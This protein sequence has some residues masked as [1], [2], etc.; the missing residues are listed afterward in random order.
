MSY[1]MSRERRLSQIHGHDGVGAPSVE[2]G[3]PA[4]VRTEGPKSA[5]EEK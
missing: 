3:R 4:S 2:E 1:G 5:R